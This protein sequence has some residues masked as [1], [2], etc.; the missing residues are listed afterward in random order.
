MSNGTQ[1]PTQEDFNREFFARLDELIKMEME[2]PDQIQ[3]LSDAAQDAAANAVQRAISDFS[4][5]GAKTPM[6]SMNFSSGDMLTHAR[7]L[8]EY[9]AGQRLNSIRYFIVAYS[10]FFTA[11]FTVIKSGMS[12]GFD[13]LQTVLISFIRNYCAILTKYL[14]LYKFQTVIYINP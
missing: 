3:R 12:S 9:H 1:T 4:D 13:Y 11:Y 14:I 8:F 7:S 5:R 6:S 10:L 2:K